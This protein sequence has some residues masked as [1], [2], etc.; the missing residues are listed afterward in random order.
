M[1]LLMKLSRSKIYITQS[2][3]NDAITLCY[4]LRIKGFNITYFENGIRIRTLDVYLI[5]NYNK[6]MMILKKK[7]L[8]RSKKHDQDIRIIF[9]DSYAELYLIMIKAQKEPTFQKHPTDHAKA[10]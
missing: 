1:I 2:Y 7:H 9:P 3:N 6:S 10:C 5:L 4:L 8:L